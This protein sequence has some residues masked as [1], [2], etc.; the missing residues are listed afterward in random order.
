VPTWADPFFLIQY[1][2]LI[3][4][5]L[6]LPRRPLS[7]AT[8]SRVVLD[9]LMLILTICTLA[10]YFVLGPFMLQGQ[11]TFFLKLVGASYPFGDLVMLCCFLFLTASSGRLRLR[12]A[13]WLLLL[14]IAL[15]IMS[16]T[17]N[18]YNTLQNSLA[19]MTPDGISM[20]TSISAYA[21]FTLSAYYMRFTGLNPRGLEE[22]GQVTGSL[23]KPQV[24]SPSLW[25]SLLPYVLVPII[26]L[27]ILSSW[28]SGIQGPLQQG[29]YI[30]GA[31]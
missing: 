25:L 21:C 26:L 20:L 10:W 16:D 13:T 1:P 23:G 2:L 11:Q 8:S 5:L 14:G 7:T 28:R 22:G 19:P 18:E 17:I 4:V 3:L 24:Q 15:L 6:N 9:S 27:L 12:P 31:A 29:V 30:G